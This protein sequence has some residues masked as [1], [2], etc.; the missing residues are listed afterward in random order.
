M[1][2]SVESLQS[3]RIAPAE[4]RIADEHEWR[5]CLARRSRC[6]ESG[7]ELVSDE[8]SGQVIGERVPRQAPGK[9]ERARGEELMRK[10]TRALRR[11][12]PLALSR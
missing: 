10:V 9:S 7:D 8:Q 1:H 3:A 5:A 11:S 4:G 12:D 6:R 2:G